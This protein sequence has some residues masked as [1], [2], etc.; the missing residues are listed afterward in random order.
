MFLVDAEK[1]NTYGK[2]FKIS[3]TFLFL[4]S[5]CLFSGL[6][7]TKMLVKIANREDPVQKQSDLGLSRPLASNRCTNFCNTDA[8]GC[9]NLIFYMSKTCLNLRHNFCADN[10]TSDFFHMISIL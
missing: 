7:F 6:Q 10:E 4:F 3:N 8:S 9:K 2:C 1:R 5:K